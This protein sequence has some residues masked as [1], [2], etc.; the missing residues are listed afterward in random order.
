MRSVPSVTKF[1]DRPRLATSAVDTNF[2][3]IDTS[4]RINERE[5]ASE[6][7]ANHFLGAGAGGVTGDSWWKA[8]NHLPSLFVHTDEAHAGGAGWP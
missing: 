1:W 6:S 7:G 8:P 4:V 2:R 3:R 5:A